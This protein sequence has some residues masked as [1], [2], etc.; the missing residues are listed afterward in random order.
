MRF[1][2]LILSIFVFSSS[3]FAQPLG[4]DFK[5]MPVGTQIHLQSWNGDKTIETFVGKKGKF[6]LTKVWVARKGRSYTGQNRYNLNGQLV[7]WNS[8]G[9]YVETYRPYSCAF[10]LGNCTHKAKST[11]GSGATWSLNTVRKGSTL[12]IT[13]KRPRD[14]DYRVNTLTLGKY[15]LRMENRWTYRGQKRWTRIVK[16][17]EP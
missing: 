11:N 15:N 10:Q 6:Y 14:S 3:A 8:G 12:T 9:S 1:L 17:V 7:R 16:I 4:I 5:R 13:A 2:A